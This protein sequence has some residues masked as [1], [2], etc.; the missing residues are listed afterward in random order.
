MGSDGSH[1]CSVR[2]LSDVKMV[3]SLLSVAIFPITGRFCRSRSPPQ[4]STAHRVKDRRVNTESSLQGPV[5]ALKSI[6]HKSGC[7]FLAFLSVMIASAA[8]H[9]KQGSSVSREK[10]TL[11]SSR[12]PARYQSLTVHRFQISMMHQ[13]CRTIRKLTHNQPVRPAF[14]HCIQKPLQRIPCMAINI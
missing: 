2:G 10:E 7:S 11:L 4:P 12:S 5:F 13:V 1:G 14:P 9:C 8:R 3:T 6:P